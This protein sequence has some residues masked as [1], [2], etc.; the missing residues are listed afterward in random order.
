MDVLPSIDS[1]HENPPRTRRGE[2]NFGGRPRP[3]GNDV[4]G[5]DDQLTRQME[6]CATHFKSF[7]D[8]IR[9]ADPFDPRAT[10]SRVGFAG[11][12]RASL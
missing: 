7:R 5:R 10:R 3:R 8:R 1:D 4:P 9:C 12:T 6:P 11:R 2:T